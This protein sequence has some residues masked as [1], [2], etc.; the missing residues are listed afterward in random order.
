MKRLFLYLF[1]G[2]ASATTSYGQK[3]EITLEQSVMGQRAFYGERT[4][5]F[6]WIP[7]TSEYSFLS[8][9]YQTLLRG[10][11]KN[12]NTSA[13]ITTEKLKEIMGGDVQY[14]N[15]IEWKDDHTFLTQ[16][17]FSYFLIDTKSQTGKLVSGV[18]NGAENI[19]VSLAAGDLAY[20]VGNK[21]YIGSSTKVIE[22]LETNIV[23][24]QAIARSEFGITKGIFWSNNGKKLAYY[25]K[26]E[27][28]VADYPLVNIEAPTAVLESIKYPMAGQS[29]EIA[30]VCIFDKSSGDIVKVKTTG[31]KDDYLTN[32]GWGPKDEFF[33]IAEVNRGQNHMKLNKYDVTGKLVKTLFEEKNDKWVEPENPVYFVNDN[34]FVWMSERDGFM[35]LYLYN[36]DGEL[37]KQLTNNKWVTNSII[38]H[39][40]KG[41]IYFEGTGADPR[42]SH[43]F[44]VNTKDGKQKQLTTGA[45]T[46]SVMFNSDY[47]LMYDGMSSFTV[48]FK[49]EIIDVTKGKVK[50]TI[51]TSTDPLT[52]INI[53][54]VDYGTIKA[55]DNKTD[56][57]YRL[58]KPSNFDATKKYPVLVYVYGGPHA[59]MITNSWLGG[60]SGWMF[61]LAEQG[62]LVYTVDNRGSANRG[63][64]FES[65]IHRNVGNA[66]IEDQMAGVKHLKSLPYVDGDRLAIHGWSFG[67]FMTSSLMLREPGT[68]NVG[69]AGGPVTDWKYYEAM[70]GE[71]YMDQPSENPEG[72]KNSSLMTYAADLEGKLLLIH[73]TSD[74]VVVMQHSMSLI[75]AFVNEGIQMDF[76]PYPMHEHNVR[77]KDRVHL[78]RKVLDYVMINNL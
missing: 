12:G 60:T 28:A 26:D 21:V 6:N 62:Y 40:S 52:N 30:G 19:D 39:D 76:F 51:L 15:V 70:Y 31:A 56:L 29:S 45:G 64:E 13:I 20:T 48:P 35:N 47:S 36:T 59:Q 18:P 27:S 8:A 2:V 63:F 14:V 54:T 41:N 69:V 46:H 33:Y 1:I 72:Y 50:R 68:F 38:G 73:G 3:S 24:G 57:Y 5:L 71:R 61:W 11:A 77:G 32:F 55:G 7:G 4:L 44:V 22:D 37:V 17:G 65:V 58:V 42:E 67:G 66:E 75:Q 9:D 53:G 10:N 34:E 78:M 49:E 25:Q 16:S 23:S 43:A 74:N